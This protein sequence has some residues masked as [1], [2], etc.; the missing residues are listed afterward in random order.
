MPAPVKPL[1]E[2]S[3]FEPPAARWEGPLVDAHMHAKDSAAMR[4][5]WAVAELYGITHAVVIADL[6][7]CR[8]L[9]REYGERVIPAVWGMRPRT[10]DLS[11]WSRFRKEREAVLEE[12]AAEGFKIV[13]LWFTPRFHE[14]Y[15][16][17]LDDPRLD[18]FFDRVQR[19][20]L[21]IL[22]HIADP[23]Y[24]F[25]HRINIATLGTKSDQ[26]PQLEHRLQQYPDILVQAAH[27]GGDPEHLDHLHDLLQRY[28]RLMLDSSAT[29]WV[30]REFSNQGDQ[31]RQ[32]LVAHADRVLF[33]TDL[34]ADP[35]REKE[36]KREHYAT[37]FWVHRHMWEQAGRFDSPIEDE[38]SPS[39]PIFRGLNLP[40]DVLRKFYWENA[41]RHY[42]IIA[43]SHRQ[44]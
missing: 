3:L 23:D 29:K 39:A 26:Y 44:A 34:V 1:A 30:A 7:V 5:Y 14:M 24:W 35:E 37:R 31:A 16:L 13:K 27:F 19:L 12:I 9:R 10:L 15:S 6:E 32:F 28:P 22:I 41:A 38:D 8:E 43:P 42:G 40:V 18:F 33:G 21:S 4:S 17:R 25:A 36:G 2:F 20:K 11:D